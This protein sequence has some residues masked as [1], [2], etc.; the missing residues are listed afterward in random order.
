MHFFGCRES[1][2]SGTITC[3]VSLLKCPGWKFVGNCYGVYC[4]LF[5]DNMQGDGYSNEDLGPLPG[6][7]FMH[8]RCSDGNFMASKIIIFV[9]RSV[10][11]A[12]SSRWTSVKLVVA[13]NTW[14]NCWRNVRKLLPWR[15]FYDSKKCTKTSLP[16]EPS[17]RYANWQNVWCCP[18]SSTLRLR[19]TLHVKAIL[20]DGPWLQN[21]LQQLSEGSIALSRAFT[22]DYVEIIKPLMREKWV[23]LRADN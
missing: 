16:I 18:V 14:W 22:C 2:E 10:A 13:I 19:T 6:P 21:G 20:L 9:A 3:H 17:V 1:R 12:V 23:C 4:V 7:R 5:F 11:S 15:N 8:F